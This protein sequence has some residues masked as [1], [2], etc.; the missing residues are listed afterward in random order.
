MSEG[1][2]F[3]ALIEFAQAQERITLFCYEGTW[4]LEWFNQKGG[5]N[6]RSG[7]IVTELIEEVV[8]RKW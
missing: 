2:L 6:Y 3:V 4:Y 8:M 7:I 1:E 5:F